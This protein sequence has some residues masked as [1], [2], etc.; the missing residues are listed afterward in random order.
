[1]KISKINLFFRKV[2]KAQI[3]HRWLC[4]F[5]LLAWT[6]ICLSGMRNF[7][8]ESSNSDWIVN[9]SEIKKN[10]DHFKEV[11]GNDQHVLVLVQADDVFAPDV[12]NMI[13]RLGERLEQEVPFADKVTSLTTISIPIGDEEG[14]EVKSPFDDG[15]PTDAQ[16]LAEKKAF[17][18]SRESI[19][20]NL[21][22]D[23]AKECWLSLKLNPFKNESEDVSAVGH[24]AEKVIMSDEFKSDRWTLMP[25][26]SA[27]TTAEKEDVLTKD[28]VSRI[29]LG[30]LVMLICLIIFVR[31]VSGVIVPFVATLF[32]IGTVLGFTG[33]LN[34]PAD[35]DMMSLPVLLGMAL[36]IGYALHYIN[37]FKMHFRQTGKRKQS[38]IEAVGESGWPILFT[39]ITTAVSLLSFLFAS[40]R[41]MV[42]LGAVAAGVVL[43]VYIYV[44]LLI[45]IF[46]SFGKDKAP[47]LAETKGATKADLI[48]EGIGKKIVKHSK[49]VTILSV[50]VIAL[51]IPGLLKMEV[52]MDYLKFMGNKVPFVQ[53]IEK[54]LETKL[55]NIYSYDVMIEFDEEDAFKDPANMFALDKLEEDLG[56]LQLT[57][58]T[59]GK[60]RVRSITRM[61]KEMYRVFNSDDSAYY[62]IPEERDML[63]QLLFFYEIS[64]SE[65]LFDELSE[66]YNAAYAHVEISDYN[67]NMIVEDIE[68]AEAAAKKYFPAAHVSVV[69]TVAENAAMNETVVISELKSF[70]ASFVMIAILL[71]IVFASIRTGLVAMIPNLAPVL[72]I[73]A[74][75]GFCHMPLDEMTMMIMPMILGIAVDDTIHFSNHI[76]AKLETGRS[77]A[78]A[79]TESFR[80]IG[81]TMGT[82]TFILCAMFL[83]YCFSPI[84]AMFRIGLLSMIGLGSALI[85]DYTLTP[86]LIYLLKPLGKKP[87]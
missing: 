57:K 76:K 64:D 83:M 42:W 65:A 45:P 75:M 59:N 51:C 37:A 71:I 8:T 3:K 60:P 46:L 63:T 74:V 27:Y 58:I 33:L 2:G 20:N 52:N 36:S 62:R 54:I 11:F 6:L 38:V 13:D 56:K 34:I 50:L 77:Y 22:S 31:S 69:G 70:A 4:L 25:I 26:G 40:I 14:F 53:R 49:L 43:M 82:T 18:M 80:E 72:L 48:F 16:E 12:L 17:I 19:V 30:F 39:V 68:A 73:G 87:N 29:G 41:P 5:V 85:A 23:N 10:S 86:A 78:D 55:G 35:S 21:V 9:G 1:M 81:K 79:V 47:S 44:V 32:G 7:R 61:V 84:T 24:A 67:A 15:I 66:S 28:F